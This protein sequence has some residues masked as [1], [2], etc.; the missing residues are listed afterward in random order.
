M[1]EETIISYIEDELHGFQKYYSLYLEY[2]DNE[3]S[4]E[5]FAMAMSEFRHC[6]FWLDI[7]EVVGIEVDYLRSSYEEFEKMLK[8]NEEEMCVYG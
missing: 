1:K 2:I 5:F 8:D 3:I 7:A 6:K 4:A